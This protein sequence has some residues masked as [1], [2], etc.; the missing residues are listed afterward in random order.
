MSEK[1]GGG[2]FFSPWKLKSENISQSEASLDV[3][4]GEFESLE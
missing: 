4:F 2:F 3:Y 1:A